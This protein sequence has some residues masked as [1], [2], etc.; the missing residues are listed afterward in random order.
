MDT[1][2]SSD[3]DFEVDSLLD[4]K[5]MKALKVFRKGGSGMKVENSTESKVLDSLQF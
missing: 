4:S 3:E 1:L 2:E 5:P